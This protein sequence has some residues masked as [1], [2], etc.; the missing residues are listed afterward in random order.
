MMGRRSLCLSRLFYHYPAHDDRERRS[1]KK[2]LLIRVCETRQRIPQFLFQSKLEQ[3]FNS[4][5]WREGQRG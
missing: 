1:K 3:G 5:E 4:K 2:Y